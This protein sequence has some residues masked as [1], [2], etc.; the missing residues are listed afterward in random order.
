MEY[1]TKS[2]Y[3]TF[4]IGFPVRG[5]NRFEIKAFKHRLTRTPEN[6]SCSDLQ[7]KNLSCLPLKTLI[8]ASL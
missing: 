8:L 3:I 7:E 1:V 2:L 4:K 6:Y 5:R